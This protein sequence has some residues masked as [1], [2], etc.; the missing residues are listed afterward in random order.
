VTLV[1]DVKPESVQIS[2]KSETLFFPKVRI[3]REVGKKRS[4]W[5]KWEI[6]F[7]CK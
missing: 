5:R 3:S 4:H 6:L 7:E 2:F 1:S